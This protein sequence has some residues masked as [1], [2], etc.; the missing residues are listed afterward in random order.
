MLDVNYGFTRKLEKT[1]L[2][3]ARE[4]ITAALQKEGFGIL[5]EIDVKATLK[6]KLDVD[7]APYV[8]LGACNPSIAH[9]ALAMEPGVGLLLPCNVVVTETAA[10]DSF[11]SIIKPEAMFSVIKKPGMEPLIE[12]ATTRLTRALAAA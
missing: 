2:A 10:G 6:K 3:A 12:E 7:V 9:Q 8:I 4:R 11:V 1:A 5:T